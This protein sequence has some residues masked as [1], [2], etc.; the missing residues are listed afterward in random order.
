[1]PSG[2]SASQSFTLTVVNINDA[3]EVG[4]LLSGQQG[5]VGQEFNYILPAGAFTDIDVGD[6]LTL[7]ASG[8]PD[9]LSFD[10]ATGLFSGTPPASS[11]GNL[12]IT[13]TA[14]DLA[15]ATA[16]QSFN[17]QIQPADLTPPITGTEGNDVLTG[18]ANNNTIRGLGGNDV[19][20]GLAGDDI[21]DGGA[22][23]DILYGGV[24][25]DTLLGGAGNDTLY[26][27]AGDDVL[28]GGA[29]NDNLYG[30]L[31]NDT[32]LFGRGDGNDIIYAD[33]DTSASKLNV[34]R[35]KPGVSASDVTATRSGLN[36]VLTITG[37]GDSV[38]I[39]SFF[40]ADNPANLNN[41]IQQV[42]FDDGTTWSAASL[43]DTPYVG[44]ESADT[45]SGN[46]R[47][48]T[49]Y[50]LGG[51]D[52]LYG[53]AGDD[54]LDGG[55]GNDYLYGGVGNDTLYGGDGNDWLYGEA[56]DDI[57]DGGAGN[58]TLNGGAG[59][60]TYRFTLGWGQ[61]TINN[62]DTSTGK[63]D[64]IEF[65]A[66]I[67]SADIALSRNN[68]DL[69]LTLKGSTDKITVTGYFSA[70]GT[71]PYRLEQIRFADGASWNF[72]QVSAMIQSGSKSAAASAS[73]AIPMPK[74][75]GTE[76]AI[77]MP[78]SGL[79][80]EPELSAPLI[81]I[82]ALVQSMAS[83]AIAPAAETAAAFA[84]MRRLP[85]PALLAAAM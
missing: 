35:F 63:T 77:P 15:G 6:Q 36:L 68:D 32:Y 2:A 82:D 14:T 47:N 67:A 30:G 7:S 12:S 5:R 20:Y 83:F 65:G 73:G 24:G 58:D 66:G 25:N 61:D 21:L 57:L 10:A 50:G 41:P 74:L 84:P 59:S 31:G 45:I 29:G 4:T 60:D 78:K 23:N 46:A 28:D 80:N 76:G 27:E 38:T 43:I 56:G 62:Y 17:L 3:P 52:V 81:G 1:D 51:N 34:L 85:E 54:T 9:W 22:G 40:E 19:L 18:N 55:S 70:N 39:N 48:N 49:I 37:T 53:L 79:C 44:T 33:Y 13:V 69:I 16:Q 11:A 64:A 8:L 72:N 26:G 71:S 75:A 42:I